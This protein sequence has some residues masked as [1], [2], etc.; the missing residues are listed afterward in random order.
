MFNI[1]VISVNFDFQR[2]YSPGLAEYTF[3]Y[4]AGIPAQVLS[5][6]PAVEKWCRVRMTKG[7]YV[8][9]SPTFVLRPAPTLSV[10]RPTSGATIA[11]GAT[12]SIQYAKVGAVG[13]VTIDLLRSNGLV[14]VS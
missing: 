9:V 7:T 6:N 12:T 11:N 8:A 14:L 5:P 13:A 10:S 2:Y 1:S 4:D 3:D